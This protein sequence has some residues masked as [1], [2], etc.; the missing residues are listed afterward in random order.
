MAMETPPVYPAEPVQP[1]YATPE[2][3]RPMVSQVPVRETWGEPE[4]E[5]PVELPRPPERRRTAALPLG[6]IMVLVA[7][8]ALGWGTYTLLSTLHVFEILSTQSWTPNWAAIGAVGGGAVLA[9]FA[10]LVSCSAL[11]RAKPKGPAALLGLAARQ[12]DRVAVLVG[13]LGHEMAHVIHQDPQRILLLASLRKSVK[14]VLTGQGQDDLLASGADTVL[15]QGYG[16]NIRQAADAGSIRML[17]ANG[18]SPQVMADFLKALEAA[19]FANP[20]WMVAAQRVP[21]SLSAQPVDA[22]RLEAFK[23]ISE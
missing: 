2:P 13:V 5:P 8:G 9:F 19:R 16:A 20:A 23:D 6:T 4:P 10:F 15:Y 18:H 21:I 12:P 14:M 1:V 17:R 11:A 7:C 22:R 3:A